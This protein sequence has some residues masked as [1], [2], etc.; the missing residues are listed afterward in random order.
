MS[1]T[2]RAFLKNATASAAVTGFPAILRAANPN[3]VLQL[4]SIGAGGMAYSDI[5]STM[6][7]P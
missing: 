6:D 7:H 4:A 2:R 5:K 1:T 3:S